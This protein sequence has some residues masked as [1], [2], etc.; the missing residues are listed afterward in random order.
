MW[1]NNLSLTTLSE[2][3]LLAGFSVAAHAESAE[4][5]DGCGNVLGWPLTVE[6]VFFIIFVMF[7]I[8]IC[9]NMQQVAC[10]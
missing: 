3:G 4:C 8:L 10:R 7:P 2:L 5:V 1:I 9:P 6:S